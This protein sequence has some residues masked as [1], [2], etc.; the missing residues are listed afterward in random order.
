MVITPHGGIAMGPMG[1]FQRPGKPFRVSEGQSV[2]KSDIKGAEAE[3]QGGPPWR[4]DPFRFFSETLLTDELPKPDVTT[5]NGARITYS[6]IDGDA[7]GGI[8]LIDRNS[9]N[10]AMMERRLL[11]DLPLPVTVSFVTDD[12]EKKRNSHYWQEMDIARKILALPNVEPACHTANHPFEWIK[13]DIVAF[14]QGKVVRTDIDLEREL[15]H[16]V[17]FIDS[18]VA[19]ADKRCEILLW[20]GRCNPP[21]E[22]VTMT[23]QLGLVNMNGGETVYD[24]A[25]PYVAGVLPVSRQVGDETQVHVSAAGDFYYTNSWTGDY[26]GMKNLAWFFEHTETP[27]RLRCM[28]VYY[29][30]YLAERQPGLDGLKAAYADIL[31]RDPAP[32]FASDYARIIGDFLVTEL[33][34]TGDGDIYVR[35]QGHLRTLRFD[36]DKPKV[37]VA[38]S[39][40]VLGSLHHNGSLYVHLDDGLE[41]TIAFAKEVRASGVPELS[42]F[43]HYT[44]NWSS[45]PD[46]VTFRA[47]GQGPALLRLSN[48]APG[49]T[50]SINIRSSQGANAFQAQASASGLLEWRGEFHG[51]RAEHDIEIR[52]A[53]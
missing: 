44:Q 20:S 16:S 17:E 18:L 50:Y 43:T 28:N 12:I 25:H 15:K 7:F 51:Y 37:D 52:R 24:A 2:M 29:H 27:R 1:V 8:S 42:Y 9:L 49:A 38:K 36:D 19:P 21:S 4:I 26:D 53:K 3:S 33:G 40:G 6:H 48:M 45:T 22:A 30:F 31:R 47:S 5:L 35:N 34:V 39:H 13:G 32:M 23:R 10:G 11:R 46:L 14:E 41:H